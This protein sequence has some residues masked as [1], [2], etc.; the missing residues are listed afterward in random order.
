MSKPIK[1]V[2]ALIAGATVNSVIL[3][4]PALAEVSNERTFDHPP[5]LIRGATS[6]PATKFPSTYEFTLT[7]PANAG[8]P[9]QAVTISQVDAAEVIEFDI[10]ESVAFAGDRY[11]AGAQLPLASIGGPE[12][13]Q[14]ETT[15]VFDPPV[16]PGTTV[17]VALEAKRNPSRSGTYLF[18]I[19]AYPIGEQGNGTFLGHRQLTFYD[20]SH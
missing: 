20:N 1:L 4:P 13:D 2:F 14:G 16:Q 11:G 3:A 12:S 7:V 9:L 17:T 8:K 18:G 15:V 6:N 5:S 19:T 10:N